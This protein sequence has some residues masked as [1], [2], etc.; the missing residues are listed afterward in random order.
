MKPK[1]YNTLE[2]L[3]DCIGKV[4]LCYYEGYSSAINFGLVKRITKVEQMGTNIN[5][6]G[7]L[8]IVLYDDYFRLT[9]GNQK[10]LEATFDKVRSSNAFKKAR[11]LTEDEYKDIVMLNAM[12]TLERWH[13]KQKL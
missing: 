6:C 7:T 13:E 5:I 9:G 3:K 4:L 2:Q 11:E 1:E 10:A 12:N 8:N